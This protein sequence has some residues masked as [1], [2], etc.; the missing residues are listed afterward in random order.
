METKSYHIIFH[1]DMNAF[2]ASCEI[3]KNPK[4]KGIPIVVAHDE[5]LRK[6]IVLTASYEAR[7]DGIKTT[8]L[9]SAR[10]VV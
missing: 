6:S 8:M 10:C 1:I 4:L 9:T 2:F 7:K 3:A 5:P